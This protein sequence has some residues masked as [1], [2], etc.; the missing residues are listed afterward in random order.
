MEQKTTINL[1]FHHDAGHGWLEV[2]KHWV[3]DLCR[4]GFNPLS[5]FSYYSRLK[6][7]YYLEEDLDAP[8]FESLAKEHL[9]VIVGSATLI[10][11]GESSN[12]RRMERAL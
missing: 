4:K 8:R 9:G 2:P 11:D 6:G 5:R 10:Y 1:N 12:I 7:C 3:D